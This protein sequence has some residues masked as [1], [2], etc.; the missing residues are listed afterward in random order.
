MQITKEI[1]VRLDCRE[2]DKDIHMKQYDKHSR[3]LHISLTDGTVPVTIPSAVKAR[4]ACKKPDGKQV[5]NDC[6][7]S[8]NAV[9]VE[10]TEQMLMA[11]GNLRCELCL[12]EGGNFAQFRNLYDP[13]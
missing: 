6:V 8:G 10:I 7:V 1:L 4:I 13:C 12:Y 3:R 9:L 5:I 11:A 2:P